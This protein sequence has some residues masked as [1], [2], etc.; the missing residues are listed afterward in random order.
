MLFNSLEFMIFLPI[1]LLVTF[2]VPKKVRY[3]WLL[4]ASYYFY[5][6]WNVSYILLIVFSTLVTYLGGLGIEWC[7]HKD[8]SYEKITKGKK[9]CVA[10]GFVSN[11]GVLCYFKYANFFMDN[12][13][14]LFHMIGVEVQ[15]PEVDVLLPVGISF[16]TFQ[17][18]SYLV[19]VYRDEIPATKNFLNYV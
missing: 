18:L 15:V 9:W 14:V 10:L 7:K 3:V 11:I 1:V 16:F 8:W 13:Q 12:I 4:I 19:D 2:I 17:A 6:C 5:M